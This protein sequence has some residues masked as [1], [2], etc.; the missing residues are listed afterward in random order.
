MAAQR[1]LPRFKEGLKL[2]NGLIVKKQTNL[3]KE[4][5][6]LGKESFEDVTGEELEVVGKT[7]LTFTVE[8]HSE[9]SRHY[10]WLKAR[11]EDI[12]NWIKDSLKAKEQ[13]DLSDYSLAFA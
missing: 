2:T 3:L 11:A 13:L 8:D 7:S 5:I 10:D 4:L 12:K 1:T 9:N 6:E